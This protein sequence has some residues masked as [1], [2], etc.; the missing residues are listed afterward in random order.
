MCKAGGAAGA[1]E[2]RREEVGSRLGGM[3]VAEETAQVPPLQVFF[4]L[5]LPKAEA[6]WE[7]GTQA[8]LL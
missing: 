6:P 8:H 7:C 1:E 4:W 3:I 5:V 2:W